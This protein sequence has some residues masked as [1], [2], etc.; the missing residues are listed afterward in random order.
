MFSS[1]FNPPLKQLVLFIKISFKLNAII[2]CNWY[3][4]NFFFVW[5]IMN[6]IT[7]A[8]ESNIEEN[9]ES[10]SLSYR[11]L[12]NSKGCLVT[13]MIFLSLARGKKLCI[14]PL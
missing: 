1:I 8:L 12:S 9:L 14:P 2:L 7:Q 4:S 6:F 11:D 5:P 13:L 10:S 3:G